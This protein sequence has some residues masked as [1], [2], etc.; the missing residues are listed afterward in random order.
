MFHY[1]ALPA[2]LFLRCHLT[3][4]SVRLSLFLKRIPSG[5]SIEDRTSN[6]SLFSQSLCR[7]TRMG[8][9]LTSLK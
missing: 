4:I 1:L 6:W 7:G 8:M 5:L 3:S 2:F 9:Y